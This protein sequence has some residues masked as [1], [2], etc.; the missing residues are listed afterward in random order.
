MVETACVAEVMPGAIPPPQG[1]GNRAAI[2]ALAALR[3][4]LRLDVVH[5]VHFII[6]TGFLRKFNQNA[7]RGNILLLLYHVYTFVTPFTIFFF[8]LLIA[9]H[10]INR[11]FNAKLIDYL[12]RSDRNRIAK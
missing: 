5:C 2:H 12:D 7:S 3:K 4:V 11:P 1:C 10:F 8:Y 6:H 9:L